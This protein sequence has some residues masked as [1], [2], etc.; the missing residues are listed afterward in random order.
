MVNETLV[1][2]QLFLDTLIITS[3]GQQYLHSAKWKLKYMEL[4]SS[5]M[6]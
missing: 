6:R 5:C 3:S 2:D 1:T 4:C